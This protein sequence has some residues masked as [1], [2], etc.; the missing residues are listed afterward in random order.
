MCLYLHVSV[1]MEEPT[2]FLT[3]LCPHTHTA[4]GS[5]ETRRPAH[6]ARGP[7]GRQPN[8]GAVR[9]AGGRKH[10]NEAA[11]GS[12][13]CAFNRQREAVVQVEVTSYSSSP[14][15]PLLPTGGTGEMVG[16]GADNRSQQGPAFAACL[17]SFFA[18]PIP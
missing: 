11:D 9:Q 8:A 2:C 15:L 1:S 4:P 16:S 10:Q 12:D 18:S 17:S 7:C 3:H 13:L 5:A 6:P 14:S